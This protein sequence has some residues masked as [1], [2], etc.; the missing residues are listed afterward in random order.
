VT[1]VVLLFIGTAF[2]PVIGLSVLVGANVSQD[3]TNGISSALYAMSYP[4]AVIGATL[5]YLQLRARPKPVMPEPV[6]EPVTTARE[7]VTAK[8]HA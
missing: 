1:T 7:L 5:L 2:G 4:F 3:I 6:A 8:Q